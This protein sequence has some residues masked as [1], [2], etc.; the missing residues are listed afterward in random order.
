M[1]GVK[2]E[3]PREGAWAGSVPPHWGRGRAQSLPRKI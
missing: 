3:A 2:I 1:G